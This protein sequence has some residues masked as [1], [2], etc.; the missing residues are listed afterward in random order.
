MH[1]LL[2]TLGKRLADIKETIAVAESV[3]AGQL[4][5]L[6]SLA[7]EASSF[8]RVG[9]QFTTWSKNGDT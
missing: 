3:T 2:N 8:S 9:L 7:P 6:L 5:T 4:Q 1:E